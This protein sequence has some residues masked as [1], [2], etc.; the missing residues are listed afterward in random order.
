MGKLE[1]QVIIVITMVA[2]AVFI[3]QTIYALGWFAIPA[4]II[5]P[6]VGGIIAWRV[7]KRIFEPK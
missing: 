6:A 2:L 5:F 7:V 3:S 4:A 1:V